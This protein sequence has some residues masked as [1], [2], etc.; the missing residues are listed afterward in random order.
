MGKEKTLGEYVKNAIIGRRFKDSRSCNT[1]QVTSDVR[2]DGSMNVV[3]LDENGYPTNHAEIY[4]LN[5]NWNDKEFTKPS[6]LEKEASAQ[7]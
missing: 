5:N 2:P 4:F 1:Y 3:L 6:K 7:K